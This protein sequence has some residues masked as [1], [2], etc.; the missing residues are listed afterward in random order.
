[1]RIYVQRVEEGVEGD[2]DE[3]GYWNARECFWTYVKRTVKYLKENF[4]SDVVRHSGTKRESFED[5]DGRTCITLTPCQGRGKLDVVFYCT[6]QVRR[7]LNVR[8]CRRIQMEEPSECS[9][10]LL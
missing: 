4:R 1:V 5:G 7:Q 3:D 6:D 10:L 9:M 2:E 8:R